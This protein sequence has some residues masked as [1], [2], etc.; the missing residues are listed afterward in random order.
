[1]NRFEHSLKFKTELKSEENYNALK[2][3]PFK[4]TTPRFQALDNISGRLSPFIGP[5]RYDVEKSFQ[6]LNKAACLVKYQKE[7]LE[8]DGLNYIIVGGF[9]KCVTPA[10]D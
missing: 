5:D 4:S 2:H 8:S 1:M 10:F 3:L 7:H 6:A 9:K